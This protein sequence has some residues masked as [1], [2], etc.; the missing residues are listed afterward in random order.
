M[1]PVFDFDENKRAFPA[2]ANDYPL[3][4]YWGYSTIQIFAPKQNYAADVENAVLEFKAMVYKFHPAG[5]E[6]WLDV[7]FNHTAE[8]GVDDP[9]DHFKSLARDHCYLLKKDGAHQ[10]YSSCVNTLKCAH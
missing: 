9:V 3:Y 4:N 10:N 8:F 5:L 2:A 7:V 6:I 1:L